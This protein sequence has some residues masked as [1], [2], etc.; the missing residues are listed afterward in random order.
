MSPR[1][2]AAEGSR[3][4]PSAHSP[5]VSNHSGRTHQELPSGQLETFVD[6]SWL[7]ILK[8]WDLDFSVDTVDAFVAAFRALLP[9]VAHCPCGVAPRQFHCPAFFS[10]SLRLQSRPKS[11]SACSA[12][13]TVCSCNE[14]GIRGV[15]QS[16]CCRCAHITDYFVPP[17]RAHGIPSLCTHEAR[18]TLLFAIRLPASRPPP[19][20]RPRP[21]FG[22]SCFN[23]RRH[24]QL[25]IA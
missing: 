9:A 6:G 18:R 20:P 22:C 21:R 14:E 1:D 19:F 25:I 8:T 2:W 13:L 16:P 5:L 15:R 24:C 3:I 11:F 17:R 4:L 12:H 7:R 10:R 23:I